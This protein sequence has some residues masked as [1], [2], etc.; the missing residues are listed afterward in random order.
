MARMDT[1]DLSS[2]DEVYTPDVEEVED[3][4]FPPLFLIILYVKVSRVKKKLP[5][6][7]A[8][9]WTTAP[10]EDDDEGDDGSYALHPQLQG[11]AGVWAPQR[12]KSVR[13]FP[14]T[15]SHV[16]SNAF[17]RF[18]CG[19]CTQRFAWPDYLENHVRSAHGGFRRSTCPPVAPGLPKMRQAAGP[20]P[21]AIVIT[22]SSEEDEEEDDEEDETL[23]ERS[24]RRMGRSHRAS[25][26]P[27]RINFSD[28]GTIMGLLNNG[29][30]T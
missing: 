20:A 14:P 27:K 1:V 25:P 29:V 17:L 6:L 12:S 9:K 21:E 7:P 22:S 24:K 19:L 16:V 5:H 13:I 11:R 10:W 28:V 26:P 23:A 15:K 18:S 30:R 4:L 2:G 8:P 3:D